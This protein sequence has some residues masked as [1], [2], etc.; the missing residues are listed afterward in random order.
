VPLAVKFAS[1]GLNTAMGAPTPRIAEISLWYSLPMAI[2]INIVG[3]LNAQLA[4][5][6]SFRGWAQPKLQATR[7][8]SPLPC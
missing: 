6:A 7:H 8:H 1:L 4:E 2:A 5:E 3:P